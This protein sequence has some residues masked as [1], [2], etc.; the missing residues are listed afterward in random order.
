MSMSISPI[1]SQV[2]LNALREEYSL[3]WHGTHGISHW[4]RVRENGLLL[5]DSTGA[6]AEVVELFSVLHDVKRR[7]E[8]RDPKHGHRGADLAGRWQGRYFNLSQ[9]ELQLLQYACKYHTNGM[10]E[11][12]ITIQT[13]WDADRLDLG[14]VGTRPIP[15]RLC[16]QKAKDPEIIAWAFN[17]SRI[18]KE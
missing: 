6:N 11:A 9:N 12:E 13:C 3:K 1:L 2:F 10:T 4:Q 15:E 7:N 5:S 18:N 8:S 17:R 14:R 16:T